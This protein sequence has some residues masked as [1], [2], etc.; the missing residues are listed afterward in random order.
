MHTLSLGLAV[1]MNLFPQA[2]E[3]DGVYVE[4]PR[5][6]TLEGESLEDLDHMLDVVWNH[7]IFSAK[8]LLISVHP[9]VEE[10]IG[11]RVI[12]TVNAW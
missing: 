3:V 8:P 1:V 7:L 6:F 9:E 12:A 5:P 11:L 4:S 10:F 2:F